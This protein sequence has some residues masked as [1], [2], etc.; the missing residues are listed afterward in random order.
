MALLPV[1]YSAD[2][3]E[4]EE[5]VARCLDMLAKGPTQTN[6]HRPPTGHSVVAAAIKVSLFEGLAG[7][8]RRLAPL[9]RA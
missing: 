5:F 3:F 4:L 9:S 6:R 1:L 8:V 2:L 7:C